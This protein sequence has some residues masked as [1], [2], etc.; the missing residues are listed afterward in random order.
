MKFLL[1]Y[2]LFSNPL[3][4]KEITEYECEITPELKVELTLID[5]KN[6]SFV[7][8]NKNTKITRCFY[9][10]LPSSKPFNKFKASADASWY[11]QISKCDTYNEKMSKKFNFSQ[12]ASFRQAQKMGTSYFRLFKD[13]HPVKCRPKLTP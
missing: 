8:K 5:P 11:L 10:T 7:L 9:Q 12:T 4:A 3:L 1:I 6:P 2:L 13:Q